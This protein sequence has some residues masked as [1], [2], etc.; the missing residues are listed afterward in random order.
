[1]FMG[2]YRT[3]ELWSVVAQWL[4]ES[5]RLEIKGLPGDTGFC[6]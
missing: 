1:M 3:T 6:Q 5:V 2:Y 4:I